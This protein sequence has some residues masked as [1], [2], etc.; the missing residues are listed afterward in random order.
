[1][2]RERIEAMMADYL[3]GEL[4]RQEEER[5]LSAL[6]QHPDLALE[7]EDLEGTLARIHARRIRKRFWPLAAAVLLSFLAGMAAD[8][9]F[10]PAPPAA[11]QWET[12]FASVYA[13]GP[14]DS[15]WA[16]SLVAFSQALKER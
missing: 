13:E 8:R 14:G 16:R 11:E 6:M 15:R 9:I 4:D 10:T 7:V 2:D 3:G 5:F 12:D 1:M